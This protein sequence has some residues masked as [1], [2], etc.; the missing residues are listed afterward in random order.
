[1]RGQIIGTTYSKTRTDYNYYLNNMKITK[2]EQLKEGMRVSFKFNG[3]RHKGW[4]IKFDDSFIMAEGA[5]DNGMPDFFYLSVDN[6]GFIQ[7]VSDIEVLPRT[8]DDLQKGDIIAYTV[9]ETGRE[10]V[11]MILGRVGD[12]IALSYADTFD[13]I[14]EW[15]T[16]ASLKRMGARLAAWPDKTVATKAEVAEKFGVDVSKV[17]VVDD[18]N[19]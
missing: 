18:S 15:R 1:M 5:H 16:L 12:L 3:V 13:D 11:V 10:I 14:C 19:N 8:L 6:E 17:K 7:D 4:S 2:P 9:K